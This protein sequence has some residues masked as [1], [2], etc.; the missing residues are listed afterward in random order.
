MPVDLRLNNR[1]IAINAFQKI[2]AATSVENGQRL[3]IGVWGHEN[4]GKSLVSDSML[5]ELDDQ[6]QAT[7]IPNDGHSVLEK[8]A[9]EVMGRAISV[10]TTHKGKPIRFSIIKNIYDMY[11]LGDFKGADY[12]V[13]LQ[14]W[15]RHPDEVKPS[16]EIEMENL[17]DP[18]NPYSLRD[19]RD[20]NKIGRAVKITLH[21]DR[22]PDLEK[23][24]AQLKCESI[25]RER[26]YTG[27]AV[28]QALRVFGSELPAKPIPRRRLAI[29]L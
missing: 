20:Q 15:S 11:D 13:Y 2:I 19:R 7:V 1:D 17:P 10:E 14:S 9:G 5:H 27:L 25:Q 8:E 24:L 16:I 4:C 21:D 12:I 28:H 18:E 23:T 22:F 3:V 26:G 6:R 29:K